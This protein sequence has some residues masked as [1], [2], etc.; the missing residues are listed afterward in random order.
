MLLNTTPDLDN[1]VGSKPPITA[2]FWTSTTKPTVMRVRYHCRFLKTG[3]VLKLHCRSFTQPDRVQFS[4]HC[5]FVDRADS[6]IMTITAG[7]WLEPVVMLKISLPACGSTRQWC[8]RYHCRLFPR[9]SRERFSNT[10]GS[11]HSSSVV[12]AITVGSM[13]AG[14]DVF[15]AFCCI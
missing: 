1:I 8:S 13:L 9:A 6:D 5:Q 11:N 2:G 12:E 15:L 7:L 4:Q 14:S 10:T 3:T